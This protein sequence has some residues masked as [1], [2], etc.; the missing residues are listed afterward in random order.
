MIPSGTYILFLSKT[1]NDKSDML[2]NTCTYVHEFTR[3]L[4][5]EHGSLAKKEP[6]EVH[7][8]WGERRAHSSPTDRGGRSRWTNH[9]TS[10]RARAHFYALNQT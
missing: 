2:M 10:F 4:N 3:G 5:I 6:S 8:T 7:F 9:S 1:K